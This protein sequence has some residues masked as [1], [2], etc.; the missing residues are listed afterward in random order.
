VTWTEHPRIVAQTDKRK[1]LLAKFQYEHNFSREEM[2]EH[3]RLLAEAK[4]NG[5]N[6]IE[7][8]EAKLNSQSQGTT[9]ETNHW[10]QVD[11]IIRGL[12]KS[13]K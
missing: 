10:Y 9:M 3:F 8:Y 1:S 13:K 7:E 5:F 2:A 4:S 12:S 6:T 11:K